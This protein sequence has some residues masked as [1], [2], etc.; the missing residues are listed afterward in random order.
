MEI[1][2]SKKAI[3]VVL[4]LSVQSEHESEADG[5]HEIDANVD[6]FEKCI[7]PDDLL[8]VAYGSKALIDTEGQYANIECELLGM[9]AGMEKF[10]T[11]CYGWSTIILSDHKPLTSIVRKDLVNA[12]TRLQCLLLKPGKSMTFADHLSC[13]VSPEASKVSTV[14][15]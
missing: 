11:F 5:L 12:P 13:N 3:V 2:T 8:P 9:V 7:I 4:L 1:D 14:P 6:H 15:N 10:H